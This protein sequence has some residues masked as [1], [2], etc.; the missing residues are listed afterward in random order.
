MRAEQA[1]GILDRLDDETLRLVFAPMDVRRI[2]AILAEMSRERA[3]AFTRTLARDSVA[4][5]PPTLAA[6]PVE[7][8]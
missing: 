4:S 7:S 6:A 1:A 2:G 3:V 8:H 5:S